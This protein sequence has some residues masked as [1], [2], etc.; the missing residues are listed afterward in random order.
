MYATNVENIPVRELAIKTL[1][2]NNANTIYLK[3]L[4]LVFH[5]FRTISEY[6]PITPPNTIGLLKKEHT[7]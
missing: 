5:V 1:N 3:I 2:N 4:L 7:R 6:I